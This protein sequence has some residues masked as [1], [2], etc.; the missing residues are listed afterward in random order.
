MARGGPSQ[1]PFTCTTSAEPVPLQQHRAYNFCGFHVLTWVWL[2]ATTQ[3][4]GQC[5]HDDVDKVRKYIQ[6]MLLSKD[7]AVVNVMNDDRGDSEEDEFR[8]D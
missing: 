5:T 4:E 1:K 8:L 2:E 7:M 3:T 6:Y